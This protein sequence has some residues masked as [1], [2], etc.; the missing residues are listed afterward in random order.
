MDL[1]NT[2]VDA[3]RV[4]LDGSQCLN[5][6]HWIVY[7]LTIPAISPPDSAVCYTPDSTVS[8]HVGIDCECFGGDGVIYTFRT[9]FTLPSGIDPSTFSVTGECA[10]DDFVNDTKVNGVSNGAISCQGFFAPFTLNQG[11]QTGMNTIDFVVE[12]NVFG[13]GNGYGVHIKWNGI[14]ALPSDLFNT[15]MDA[16]SAAPYG[17]PLASDQCLEDPH[18]DADGIAALCPPDSANPMGAYPPNDSVSRMIATACDYTE[19]DGAIV[20][21]TTTFTMPAGTDPTT[22]ALCG[23]LLS[24]NWVNEIK[25]NGTTVVS[26]GWDYPNGWFYFTLTGTFIAGTNVIDFVL[27]NDITGGANWAMLRV[28]WLNESGGGGGDND[29]C[30]CPPPPAFR[31]PSMPIEFPDFNF[32]QLYEDENGFVFA[33]A[34]S[35]PTCTIPCVQYSIVLSTTGCCLYGSGFS[36]VAVGSGTV[37]L[38]PCPSTACGDFVCDINGGGASV[39]VDDCDA[40]EVTIT[41]PV[42]DSCCMCC[43]S[44]STGTLLDSGPPIP[45]FI[46]QRNTITGKKRIL[47]NRKNLIDKIQKTRIRQLRKSAG[48]PS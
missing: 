30:V 14:C 3:N 2:G 6:P 46:S 26:G 11:F 13:A 21:Y 5:D 32:R 33:Q 41:P 8:R 16:T 37:T 25:L 35:D 38:A 4:P 12:N 15:G 44:G 28:E 47:I 18:W 43:L 17:T 34:S 10:A 42:G 20:T 27:T 45:T 19:E 1:Y 24:D 23:R 48:R 29:G 36:F 22:F 39:M 40:V 31:A 9:T 7:E